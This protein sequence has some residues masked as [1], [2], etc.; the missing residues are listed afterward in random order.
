MS[1]PPSILD[2]AQVLWW[3]CSGEIAFGEVPGAEA[4]NRLIY[5]FAVCR[6]DRG[7]IYRF[8]CNRHWEVVQDMDHADEEEAKANLQSQYDVSRVVWQR[9]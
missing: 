3:A 4:D 2:G 6:Y 8:T 5:G 1:T 9:Y 7:E